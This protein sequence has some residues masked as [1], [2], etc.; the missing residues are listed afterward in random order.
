MAFTTGD[1]VQGIVGLIVF[2]GLL[3]FVVVRSIQKAEDPALMIFKWVLTVGMLGVLFGVVMPIV[4]RNDP[5]A[6]WVGVPATAMCGLVLAIVWGRTIGALASKPL[7][8][9]YDGGNVPP[10]PHPFYSVA[11][12][13]Q[14]QGRYLEAVEEVRKQLERFPTDVEGQLLLAQIQAENLKDLA[15]AELTIQCFCEQP[16]HAPQNIVFAL[17]SMADWHLSVGQDAE[18]ARGQLEKLIERMPGSEAALGAAQRIA[19]LGSPEMRLAPEERKKFIVPEGVKHL[20]LMRSQPRF[21]A[22]EADPAT[23]AEAYVKHLEE[24]PMDTEAREKLAVLYVD[25]YERLDLATGELEQLIEQPNQPGRLVVHWLNL[26]AD[27]Q[28]R[29]G[30]DYETVRQTLQRVIDR[31][32]NLAPA[33]I[34]RNRLALLKLELK[35]KTKNPS[36]QLGTYEQNLGLKQRLPRRG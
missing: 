16:G 33:E 11:L 14:K 13:R 34:A 9:L 27:L 8:A 17:Y 32:P 21:H 26:L 29:G 31:G 15:A 6:A 24:H 23:Q 2:G 22:P 3:V 36:V 18:A 10:V 35:G 7:T 5:S 4:A 25:H 12:A 1:M 28:V 30:A 20:G 19:H